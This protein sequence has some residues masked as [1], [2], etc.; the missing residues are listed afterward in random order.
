MQ[1]VKNGLQTSNAIMLFG[2]YSIPDTLNLL[3]FSSFPPSPF[4]PQPRLQFLVLL[5][6]TFHK[7]QKPSSAK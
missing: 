6:V 3:H 2:N 7:T 4:T 5:V 1:F